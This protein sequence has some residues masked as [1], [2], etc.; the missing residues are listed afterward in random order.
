MTL[1]LPTRRATRALQ[2]AFLAASGGAALLLP[3][4]R[5]IIG[6]R[7]DL[8]PVAGAE[9]LAA[10]AAAR[11][12]RAIGE[13]ERQLALAK[14]VLRWAEAERARPGAMAI[15]RLC[16]AGAAPRRRRPGSRAS[17]PG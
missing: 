5:P 7:E 17:W 3:K 6:A 2:E 11:R 12:T 16:G 10:G 9:D 15:D 8:A 13:I 4:I 1:L 14:L